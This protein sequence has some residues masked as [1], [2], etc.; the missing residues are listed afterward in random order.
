M[1]KFSRLKQRGAKLLLL[2]IGVFCG[3]L[4]IELYV[5]LFIKQPV[6]PRIV[7]DPGY[8][9]RDNMRNVRIRHIWPG[10]YDVRIT[11]DGDGL[12]GERNY[13]RVKP[14]GV[15]RVALVGDS[16]PFGFGVN[17]EEVVSAKLATYLGMSRAGSSPEVLNFGVPGFG[18]AEELV[19][20][21]NKVRAYSPDWVVL[22]FCCDNDIGDNAVSGLFT[23]LPDGGVKRVK[24]EFL[25]GS[26]MQ[27]KLYR[28]PP[29]RWLF[30][31]SQLWNYIRNQL[32]GMVQGRLL[33]EQ[34]M[35]SYDD[36]TPESV[37]LT[38]ALLV[39]LIREIRA[40]GAKPVV[41][42][43]PSRNLRSNF[44]MSREEILKLG[45]AWVDGRQFLKPEDYY[46]H[47]EHWRA[48]GH[49]KAARALAGV[50]GG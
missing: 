38:R 48:S 49:D 2:L 42:I 13:S 4:L 43:I 22:F 50:I 1:T 35:K 34:G 47:D 20:Y 3:L 14:P 16:F 45:A 29:T 7:M 27:E 33:R 31:H 32:S 23:V 24:R 19:Q 37:R 9:V 41:F 25:P 15:L 17:D 44:P 10:E 8:G 6:L 40:D 11:T 26:R 28:F 39:E 30:T 21:Q 46:V 36:S 18:Q 12:R 5:R